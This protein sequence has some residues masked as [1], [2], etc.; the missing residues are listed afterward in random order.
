M[1]LR[2][3]ILLT[4]LS[5]SAAPAWSEELT[6]QQAVGEA[7]H[8]SPRVQK[9]RSQL[10]E[11][12]WKRVEAY[13]GFLPTI[14]LSGSYLTDKDYML[15]D[16][17]FP[18]SPRV[19]SIPQILPTSLATLSLQWSLFDGLSSTRKLQAANAFEGAAEKELNWTQF[20]IEL[21]IVLNYYRAL[22]A[23][24]LKEVAEQNVR[25]LE[26]HLK[27]VA[28]FKSVGVGT[29]YDVLRVEVQVSEAKSELLNST[30]NVEI[31]RLRLNEILGEETD[32]RALKGQLPVLEGTL[33]KNLPTP[34]LRDRSDVQ[35]LQDRVT[36]MERLSAAAGSY[37][38]PR[39][40]V[41]GNYQYYNNI[42][43]DPYDRNA[44]RNAHAVGL[45]LTW[46]LFDGLATPA[47]A[48]QSIEQ[49]YQAEKS[50]QSARLKALQDFEFW[51]RK[52]IYF[53]SIY[54]SRQSDIGK[55]TESV[56][57]AKAGRK[58]GTRTSTDLLDSELE[59]FRARAG[60]INAQLG[61]IEAL[62]QLE[63]ASGKKLYDFR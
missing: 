13:S 31:S 54:Q 63:L 34:D 33:A 29:N 57:L 5:T 25:T 48:K 2:E 9:S 37:Y 27:D 21:D 36:G 45:Q 24:T 26:D 56:R 46:N 55:S 61:S 11:N 58:A 8:D 49:K 10:E 18:G 43:D 4:L 22:A 53:C 32:L 60:A 40:S 1:K 20:Q 6:L 47:K 3:F 44:F 42:N 30:D 17:Q 39:L 35:A 62:I 59:L 16:F 7:M 12:S 50:L 19:V 41:F 15:T 28:L 51:R 14:S 52:Y 23:Q 38:M